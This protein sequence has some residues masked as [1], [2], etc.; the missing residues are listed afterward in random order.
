MSPYPSLPPSDHSL[1]DSQ[2]S[3]AWTQYT[4]SLSHQSLQVDTLHCSPSLSSVYVCVCINY[5]CV[6]VL[7]QIYPPT[8]CL[9][10][11]PQEDCPEGKVS[12]SW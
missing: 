12:E 8:L 3:M 5:V 1:P 7:C 9:T 4:D 11:P 10:L 6:C 2:E